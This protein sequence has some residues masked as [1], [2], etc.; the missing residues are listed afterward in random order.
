M[1]DAVAA[2]QMAVMRYAVAQGAPWLAEV[3]SYYGSGSETRNP[4]TI[5]ADKNDLGLLKWAHHAGCPW[6]PRGEEVCRLAVNRRNLPML[7]FARQHGCPWSDYTKTRA[8]EYLGYV[9]E[10]GAAGG[11]GAAAI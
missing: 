9:E 6:N 3:P 1:Y 4:L 8:F 11:G 10:E 2:G 7:E 5:L